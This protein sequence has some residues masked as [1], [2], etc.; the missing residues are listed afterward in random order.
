MEKF[1]ENLLTDVFK[2]VIYSALFGLVGIGVSLFAGWQILKGVYITILVAGSILMVLSVVFLVGTPKSRV[3][4]FIKGKIVDGKIEK[5]GKDEKG[6]KDFS[7]KGVSPAIIA[8]VMV[9]IAFIIEA[10]MH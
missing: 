3:E 1:L 5:F 7:K 8:I 4:Y 9:A 10:L 2:G 6:A